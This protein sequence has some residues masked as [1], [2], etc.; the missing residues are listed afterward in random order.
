PNAQAT[1]PPSA[2]D[3][4]KPT[5]AQTVEINLVVGDNKTIPTS[6]VQSYSVGTPGVV[7]VKV[8]PSLDQFVVVALRPG[9][10]TVLMLKRRGAETT[11][12]INV[13]ARSPEVVQ[14]EIEALLVGYTG[15]KIRSVGPRFFIEGGV[16]TD[17]DAKRIG[18]IASLYPGQ[19]ESLVV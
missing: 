7:D 4:Q 3:D 19:V 14:K 17:A 11:Y 16:S 18:L 9:S 13:Y 1:I 12:A 6:D 10:T 5:K 2:P 8:A 15:L